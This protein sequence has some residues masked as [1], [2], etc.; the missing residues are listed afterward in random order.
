MCLL[1]NLLYFLKKTKE[2]E[3]LA[4]SQPVLREPPHG[5]FCYNDR[6]QRPRGPLV[7]RDEL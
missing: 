6:P 4:E 3:E 5:P 2:R 1:G 7:E